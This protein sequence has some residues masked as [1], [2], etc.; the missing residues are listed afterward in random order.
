MPTV[1]IAASLN[2]FVK[3]VRFLGLIESIGEAFVS[4]TN[5][6]EVEF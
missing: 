6:L 5:F 2:G 4:D 3:R 1:D